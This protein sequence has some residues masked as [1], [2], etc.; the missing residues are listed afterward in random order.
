[1]HWQTGIRV[2]GRTTPNPGWQIRNG[3]INRLYYIHSGEAYLD[4]QD[5]RIPLLPG[6]LYLLPENA[7]FTA[8]MSDQDPLDHTYF[9]FEVIPGFQLQEILEFP[10]SQYPLIQKW[11]D[12]VTAIY[13]QYCPKHWDPE[14]LMLANSCLQELLW[15]LSQITDLPSVS[16]PRIL[17]TM[18]YIQEHLTES[19]TVELLADRLFLDKHYF[20][21]LF[22]RNT[23][24]PPHNYIQGKR[25]NL[26][27]SLLQKGI[28]ATE[29]A[30]QCGY[31]SYSTFARAFKDCYGCSPT[32]YLQSH[33][34]VNF[35]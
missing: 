17:D 29:T 7:P 13:E 30:E 22:S 34:Q 9:D 12:Y 15:I 33:R 6:H 14:I 3:H 8:S 32:G 5:A 10:V 20:I 27:A 1:M 28:S 16:D 4:V 21:R 26:A 23:G 35:G 18:L 24:Q 31:G 25:L 2:W 19:L 11:L